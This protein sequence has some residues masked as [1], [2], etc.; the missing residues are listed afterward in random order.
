MDLKEIREKTDKL[1][2]QL[3]ETLSKRFELS[4]KAAEFKIKHSLPLEDKK[5]EE[6]IINDKYE[7]LKSQGIDDRIF[8]TDL[9]NVIIS[10]SKDLQRDIMESKK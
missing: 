10:K 6:E 4:K 8:V 1:D 9:F 3:I 2:K 7:K 5:R